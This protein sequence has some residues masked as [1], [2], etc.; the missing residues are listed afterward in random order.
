[1]F[2][3]KDNKRMFSEVKPLMPRTFLDLAQHVGP[4]HI[5]PIDEELMNGLFR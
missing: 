5:A 4:I 2:D 1:M 3:E